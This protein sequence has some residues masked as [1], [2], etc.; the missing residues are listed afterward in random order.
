[1]YAQDKTHLSRVEE[2]LGYVTMSGFRCDAD[3]D[4]MV[5][6]LDAS[7]AYSGVQ[8]RRKET[9]LASQQL[10]Q[11]L[12][13]IRSP[14]SQDPSGYEA[15]VALQAPQQCGVDFPRY[16]D[17]LILLL[18]GANESCCTTSHTTLQVD[19]ITIDQYTGDTVHQ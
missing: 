1:M 16:P 8:S 17:Q 14:D 4:S 11:T 13:R 6:H 10:Q 12:G 3:R 2:A 18:V 9:Q 15:D 5:T 19:A 7:V